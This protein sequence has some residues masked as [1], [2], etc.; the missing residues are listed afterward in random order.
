[1]K[2]IDMLIDEKL[3][4]EKRRTGNLGRREAMILNRVVHEGL[5]LEGSL[6]KDLKEVRKSDAA[7]WERGAQAEGTAGAKALR[8]GRAC[9]LKR[10]EK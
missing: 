9:C 3:F 4:R 5:T 7:I 2:I 1:M 6:S 10:E 8:W